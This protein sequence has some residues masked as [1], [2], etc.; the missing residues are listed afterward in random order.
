VGQRDDTLASRGAVAGAEA[1]AVSFPPGQPSP[2]P[3]APVVPGGVL[4][5]LRRGGRPVDLGSCSLRHLLRVGSP[6]LVPGCLLEAARCPDPANRRAPGQRRAGRG[7]QR[8]APGCG[9][10]RPFRQPCGHTGHDPLGTVQPA[11]TTRDGR[12]RAAISQLLATATDAGCPA[13]AIE[14]LDFARARTE[15]REHTAARPSG[16]GGDGASGD[17]W[18]ASRRHASGTAWCRWRPTAGSS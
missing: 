12:L 3:P 15:G 9:R 17:W 7:P 16:G 1:A 8:R 10:G 4:P 2:W 11:R 18:P 13:I 6:P 14:D 5:P